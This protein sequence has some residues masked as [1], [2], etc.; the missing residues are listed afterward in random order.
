MARDYYDESK[1]KKK[2]KETPKPQ[3][4]AQSP[5]VTNVDKKAKNSTFLGGGA[6]VKKV[7]QRQTTSGSTT[8]KSQQTT[9]RRGMTDAQ[10]QKTYGEPRRATAQR[11]QNIKPEPVRRTTN[12]RLTAAQ[13]QKMYGTTKPNLQPADERRREREEQRKQREE[14]RLA[15]QRQKS[16][17]NDQ[18]TAA[19][20]AA[21]DR[22]IKNT[23]GLIKKAGLDA[24]SGY[25]QTLTDVIARTASSERGTEA[26]AMKMGIEKGT[27]QYQELEE[28]RKRTAE[29]AR[30]DNQSLYQKMQERQS[31]WD[32]KTKDAKG[33]EKAYYG[34][35]ESGTG[36]IADAAIGGLTGTGQVGALAS[37]GLRTYGSSANQARAE[38][39]TDTEAGWF[40][41]G[42][43]V[44]EMGTELIGGGGLAKAAY[45][46]GALGLGDIATNTL[47]RNL[48]GQTAD[49]AH[50]GVRLVGDV[51]EENIEE[52][53]GWALDPWIKELTYGRNVRTREAQSAMKDRSDALRAEITN[54]DDA[55]AAAAYL[56]SDDFIEQTKQQYIAAGLKEKDAE[57]VAERMRDY[58]T[59]SLT[60]DTD[61][62]EK[63]EDEVS[64]KVAGTHTAWS[65]YSFK[66]LKETFE[67]TSLLVAATG[68]PG[69]ISTSARGSL[70]KE[71]LGDDG[72]RALANTAI[73]FEDSGMSTKARAMAARIE[74]GKEL[75]GTQ[76]YELQ[77]GMQEQ[78]RK[79]NEREQSSRRMAARAIE[80]DNLLTPYRQNENGGIDLDEVTEAAYRESAN[81]AGAVIDSLT[82]ENKESITDTQKVD[83]SKAIAGFQ[84]GVFTVDDANTLNYSNTTVRAAFE[85]ST[86]I[87]LGQYIVRNKDGSVN[88][89]ATNTK[90]KDA[91]FAM[92][93]DNLVKSAQAETQNW[94]DNAKGQV[95]TQVSARMGAQGSAVLQQALDD[96]DE[97]DRSKYMMTANATDM[98]Y[99]AA[100]N[101][102]TEWS[103][104]APEATRMFPGI[105]ES[106]LKMMYEAGL[107]DRAMANDKARGRQVRMGQALTEVGE[108]ETAT[109]KVFIDTEVPPKGSVIRTFTEIAKNLGADIHFVDYIYDAD[110]NPIE[111]ANG[112]YDPN[113]NTFYL[114][115]TTGAETNIGYIFMHETTHYLK[116]Y[117]PEQYQALENLVRERWFAFNPSQM[118]DAIARKIEAYKRA[119]KG[120]Q[121]LT[122][123][124]ALEEIIADAS[125]DFINDPEFARQVAEEDMGLAK[126]VLDSIRNALRMLRRIFASGSIDD[127]THMNSLFRELDIMT[128]AEKLWLDAYKVAV[129]NSA[130]N[131]VNAWQDKVNEAS[132]TR[133]T[134]LYDEAN[135][136]DLDMTNKTVEDS[137]GNPI[138]QFQ[139][140]GDVSFSISSYEDKGRDTYIKYLNKN[141]MLT[142]GYMLHSLHGHLQM[143]Y[144]TKR[145][146]QYS[147]QSKRI[148]STK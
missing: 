22:A 10:Y 62:M 107:E 71:Q 64:K 114:N 119:T 38:G 29:E 116:T 126:A 141:A 24:V 48:K 46:K 80:N 133:G 2:K 131:A 51:A 146:S 59:A 37:M 78:V 85:A 11:N 100:R 123:E 56:S 53:A 142:V 34:A 35:V 63:I 147:L 55:R 148:L 26:K 66:E 19:Q 92:A 7:E 79:D 21:T 5:S 122:E 83:G 77:A 132:S 129:Q 40:G 111:G 88:I 87:D 28:E 136:D 8:S 127:D 36:M 105:S 135:I 32:E 47:I 90:T 134:V 128:E 12:H 20:K 73:D 15:A 65:D 143:L 44:K 68:L 117:A 115:V 145:A 96:V 118:Q 81:K 91:L 75:T 58:L 137:D 69:N 1:P 39:A 84:T 74:E 104:I 50:I 97:R 144:T 109:G 16:G 4:V 49:L 86:G 14:R 52:A 124:Q 41:L 110:N 31:E 140:N 93:A 108:Q 138:A 106:K 30:K 72:V 94:M 45:G 82:K 125:H 70:V 95:V 121:V 120:Q 60:G 102:G 18:P 27:K 23:P 99:Q 25:G 113:T 54:E 112:S 3:K 139:D 98:L 17:L 13:T 67:A 89:P 61:S 33:F 101:M 43:A 103:A 130:I 76:V 57:E 6:T 9:Q 42:Q